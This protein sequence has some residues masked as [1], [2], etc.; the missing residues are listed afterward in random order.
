[1]PTVALADE[2][3]TARLAAAL[4]AVARAG[5]FLALRGP[6]GV[7]KTAFARAF[8]GALGG[9]A[10]EVPSPT[11]TLVQTYD[12]PSGS[13]WHFDLYRLKEPGELRE[14]G[15]DEALAEGL[16]LVEWPERIEGLLPAD[17]LDLELS[18]APEAETARLA[19][20]IG[21]GAWVERLARAGWT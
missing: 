2:A 10:E 20:L 5:D 8:I 15:F 16:V 1:M 13:I 17:R 7:G 14:L 21:R 3:A 6:L 4:A 19:R 11:F 18:F 9:G 12:T